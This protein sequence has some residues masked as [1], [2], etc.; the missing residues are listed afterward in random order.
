MSDRLCGQGQPQWRPD[1]WR[2]T[3]QQLAIPRLEN[4]CEYIQLNVKVCFSASGYVRQTWPRK[5]DAET[6]HTSAQSKTPLQEH[7]ISF[8]QGCF[9]TTHTVRQNRWELH[10][11]QSCRRLRGICAEGTEVTRP[12]HQS[13]H[14][15]FSGLLLVDLASTADCPYCFSAVSAAQGCRG[16]DSFNDGLAHFPIDAGACNPGFSFRC[17]MFHQHEC[18]NPVEPQSTHEDVRTRVGG[19]HEVATYQLQRT[20]CKLPRQ[21]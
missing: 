11:C 5:L 20:S 1:V 14:K 4:N 6:G 13:S 15:V 9:D 17:P 2:E 21:R 8:A 16:G 7:E 12:A 19:P 18:P 10:Q 3:V